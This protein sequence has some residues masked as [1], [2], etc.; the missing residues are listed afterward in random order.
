[1]AYRISV[2]VAL[3]IHYF[4]PFTG[5]CT[6]QACSIYQYKALLV[7]ILSLSQCRVVARSS[8]VPDLLLLRCQ[9]I[10]LL[11]PFRRRY[12]GATGT[13]CCVSVQ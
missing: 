3:G 8:L 13:Y 7:F 9:A 5:P 1:M 6:S 4:Y 2:K 10:L 12:L 11:R